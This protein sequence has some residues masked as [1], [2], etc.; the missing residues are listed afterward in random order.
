MAHRQPAVTGA[1]ELHVLGAARAL[2]DTG[3]GPDEKG[4]TP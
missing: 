4:S 2:A 3:I 1:A